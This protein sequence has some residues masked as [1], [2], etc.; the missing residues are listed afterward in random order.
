[1][2][3][4][5]IEGGELA[6]GL[7]VPTYLVLVITKTLSFRFTT[8]KITA[9]TAATAASKDATTPTTIAMTLSE[10]LHGNKRSKV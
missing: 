1:M 9:T 10:G 6:W 5:A 8:I 7:E 4:G 2:R 3:G